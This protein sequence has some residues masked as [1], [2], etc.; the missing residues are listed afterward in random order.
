MAL[1]S[2]MLASAPLPSKAGSQLVLCSGPD[3]AARKVTC[4]V[5][6]DTGWEHGVK[7]RLEGVDTPEY[8]PHAE[9]TAEVELAH[10]AT[11]R[12][13]Q[14]MRGG[15]RIEWLHERGRYGRDLV[16][17]IL[18]DGRD[19][20]MVLVEE[21]LAVIWPHRPAVFCEPR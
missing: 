9:C 13:L 6:G 15:Y 4:L 16:N 1:L 5:D 10:A 8:T 14:L 2:F 18:A 7:W 12:M 3:R 17:I 11:E 19:A 20:G 21:K